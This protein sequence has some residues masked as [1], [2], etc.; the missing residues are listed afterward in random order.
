MLVGLQ[1][2]DLVP[3]EPDSSIDFEVLDEEPKTGTD[4]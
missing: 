3:Y 2:V 4:F 1:V